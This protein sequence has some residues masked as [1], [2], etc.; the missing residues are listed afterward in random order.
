MTHSGAPIVGVTDGSTNFGTL[1]TVPGTVTYLAFEVQPGGAVYGSLLDSQPTVV[2]KDQF[3]ND[4]TSGL[5]SNLD[6]ILAKTDGT[7][8]LVG[9]A[10][11]D[12]G[13]SA[14]NGTVTFTDLTVNEFGTGKQLTASAI[15]LTDAVSDNFE[16]TKKTLTA[17]I[18]AV[19][20]PYDGNNTATFSN[21]TASNPAFSDVLTLS[22]GTAT[23]ADANANTN[24]TVTATGLVLAGDNAGN[25]TYDNTATGLADITPLA[26][27]ITPTAGQTK[28]YGNAD[29]V[30]GY[31]FNPVLISP[32]TFSGALGRVANEN[33]GTYAFT[34]GTLDAGSNYNLTLEAGIFEITQR[35]ITVEATPSTKIY[36]GNLSSAGIPTITVGSLAVGDDTNFIQVY[37]T[38]NVATGKKLT[39][40]GTAGG[41]GGNNYSYTFDFKMN[42]TITE[43]ELTVSGLLA[44]NKTYDGTTNA[45]VTGAPVLEGV[46]S[47][48]TVSLT[49]TAT[50]EF[51]T[52]NVGTNSVI[53][54]S[55]SITGS[56]ASNYTLTQP[57]LSADI[58]PLNITG[59]FTADDKVYDGT[60]VATIL[61]RSLTGVLSGDIVNVELVG[62]SASFSTRNV[63]D[64]LT[65]TAT[66]MTLSGSAS[67][68]YTLT[69][70]NT[71]TADITVKSINVI[72]QADTKTYDG[73]D[74]SNAFPLVGTP[75]I[76]DTVGTAPI[77]KFDNK[78]IGTGKTLTP[79]GLVISDGNGGANYLVTNVPNTAGVI[80]KKG[81]TVT[82][83]TS[84]SRV[85]DGGVTAIVD[86]SGASLVGVVSG[87]EVLVSLNSTSYSATFDNKNVSTGKTVTVSGL[88]LGGDGAGN[89]LLT[90][91]VLSDGVITKRTL[92]VTATG[93]NK[94]YD[95]TTNA[96]VT[97]SDNR[98]SDDILTLDYTA[99]FT[100]EKNVG[101]GKAI[102]VTDITIT[103]G[104][105]MGNYV[106][107]NITTTA[108]ANITPAPL[109]A[110]VTVNKKVVDGN[111]SATIT[112]VTLN[113]VLLS[114]VVT[115]DNQG[116]A[117]FASSDVGTHAVTSNDVTITGGDAGNYDFNNTATGTGEILLVPTIVY[118]DDNWAGIGAWIDPDG[119]GL[120][121]YFGY[122]AFATIQEGIDAVETGGTVNVAAGTYNESLLIGKSL[123]LVGSDITKPV[124]IGLAPANYI[125]KVNGANDV[126]LN[127]LE[128]NGNT[129]GTG[130]N[131]FDYGILVDNSGTELNPVEIFNSTVKN[132]WKTSANGI[133]ADNGSYV[134]VH[135]NTVSSF[136]KRG[137]RYLNSEGKVYSNEVIGDN[138]DGTERVQNLVNIYDGSIVEIY[139][140][141]LYNALT[142]GD[143]P[144]WTSPAI[145]VSSYAW[146][147]GEANSQANIHNNE[148]YNSDTGIIVGSAFATV[149]GSTADIINNN[150]HNLE[151][152]ISFEQNTVSAT[153]TGNSFIGNEKAIY[154]EGLS[155]PIDGPV[156]NAE[157]NWWGT[158]DATMIASKI[159]VVS[160]D[161]R[162]WC[163]E[164]TCTDTDATSPTV[165]I[166][167]TETSPT[168]TSPIPVTITFS[169]SVSGFEIGDI[170]VTN[171][172]A[173]NLSTLDNT[174]YTADITPTG[175]GEITVN[176]AANV[177]W[178]LAGNY[179]E[180]ALEFTIE[181]DSIAPTL[182]AVSIA[183]DNDDPTLAKEGD[184]ITVSL[185]SNEN[186]ETPT[187]TIAGKSASVTGGPTVWNAE[188]TVINSDTNGAVSF[189]IAFTDL[190]GNDGSPVSAVTDGSSVEIDTVAPD[191]PVITSIAGDGYINI[192][193][194]ATIVVVG[195]AEANST[196]SVSLT[197]GATVTWSG[198]AD[199]TT[200]NYSINIEGTIL[201]DG[202]ITP[203]VTATD[204]AGNVSTATISPT[205]TKDV[206]APEIASHTPGINAVNVEGNT[207]TITFNEAVNVGASDITL[208]FPADQTTGFDVGGSGTS[209][210]TLTTDPLE[211][212]TVYTVTIT[213]DVTDE[214]G[215]SIGEYDWQ[216][217][218]A[219]LYNIS[220]S[221]TAGGWNLIS[222]PVVPNNI[223]ISNVLGDAEASIGAVWTYDPN[224]SNAVDG[225][226]VYVPGNPE[227][228]NNLDIITAGRG[229]WVSVTSNT[230]ISGSGSLLTV[231]PTT[232]PSRN[233]VAGWNLVGYYQIPGENSSTANEAFT[234]LG[235]TAGL[236]ALWGFNNSEGQYKSV[237]TILP[238][239]AFWISL[240]SAK[241]YTPS[242][243]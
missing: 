95:A 135:N 218:T 73:T 12:I 221:A 66:G 154:A 243:L 72:A 177:A 116:T 101:N 234:S 58:D 159:T 108:T 226:L 38:T 109:T 50:G 199:G 2:T 217:T 183:S 163:T 158:T 126:V 202:T 37:A 29:P 45:T 223:A 167:S 57:T 198:T 206:V 51:N 4:S 240:P 67:G 1:S 144:T 147:G 70:V 27:T 174:V 139:G 60:T 128:I 86:F 208:T 23:F 242:N 200:G 156:V 17:T 34:L 9:D 191:A 236:S 168:N 138:V 181:S 14:G 178:D 69:S 56:D 10:T 46:V 3:G 193:E 91:P 119:E 241:V 211:S 61:T 84:N 102:S 13:T 213:V 26:I 207:I 150:L 120:A 209:V 231:G 227:D 130:S 105:D 129:T 53:V 222:L 42:G 187:V 186:I 118:V 92:A 43:K 100:A 71:T 179:N 239:D 194:Q 164:S 141:T 146:D 41:N 62:G 142:T 77:Q 18:T 229:Y 149:D 90:Q 11:L 85:Y 145:I 205:A 196:V 52:P 28:V 99:V 195:T 152:A 172:T 107:G 16:I 115:I 189:T 30:F 93:L 40:S 134:L 131:N 232:P 39:P 68:N 210:I 97:L 124:I 192:S 197:G 180:V 96:T 171:G 214:A 123:T 185:T 215:N 59:S 157:H 220:L 175:D 112:G 82:G 160:V 182:S 54:S 88:T 165:G 153:I 103:G 21:P 20:K 132:I 33:V 166:S 111:T 127:N 31:T 117:T 76:G 32:D 75:E 137:I 233:L 155:G 184:T 44:A 136:H 74:S 94:V 63:G 104:A 15:G 176:I 113:G 47:G 122:D 114:D 79:S 204:A 162:P 110:T 106:L 225:W 170:V 80:N 24:K 64:G 121:T 78:N 173:G 5:A 143:T 188:Y 216:F 48:D 125:I 190:A 201:T 22:G 235:G 224:D 81:L 148:I 98:V 6:V 219:T 203:L 49:G 169:E 65:V 89:Y 35:P 161:Y 7:G 228:T 36:D 19:S 230:T 83:A 55:L 133:E 87:E 212:N 8:T 237:T 151:Q 140:N 238:G 25:Y